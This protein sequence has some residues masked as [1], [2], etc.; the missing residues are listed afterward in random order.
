MTLLQICSLR[1]R[2]WGH[3][4]GLQKDW[5]IGGW[6]KYN[7]IHNWYS[8]PNIVTKQKRV[9]WVTHTAR[10]SNK[11][12]AWK[13]AEKRSFGRITYG[14][15]DNI[16]I[17]FTEKV[18][19]MGIGF[20]R[21]MIAWCQ[22][23]IDKAFRSSGSIKARGF[24]RCWLSTFQD[25]SC[26]TDV[27][28]KYMSGWVGRIVLKITSYSSSAAGIFGFVIYL[29]SFLTFGKAQYY[30][31]SFISRPLF[32]QKTRKKEHAQASILPSRAHAE[33]KVLNWNSICYNVTYKSR[34]SAV[35]IATGY[36]LDD[37][38]VDVGMPV[39]SRLFTSP[40]R[41]DRLWGPPNLLSNGYREL[42][43]RW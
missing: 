3:Y 19:K 41:P 22:A 34:D 29:W 17:H 1:T 23:F 36:E 14:W 43:P 26:S 20:E 5:V 25:G 16:K 38:G 9:K 32:A 8:L 4:F 21:L 24:F 39:G 7:K 33:I 27:V 18:T 42:F 12:V 37:R 6:R 11:M 2:C 13:T 28:G 40:R 30:R 31:E 15:D 10:N 35:G